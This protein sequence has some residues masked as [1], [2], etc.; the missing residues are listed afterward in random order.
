[1]SRLLKNFMQDHKKVLYPNNFKFLAKLIPFAV[2]KELLNAEK[3]PG[4]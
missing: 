3:F 1:M 4:P 2:A